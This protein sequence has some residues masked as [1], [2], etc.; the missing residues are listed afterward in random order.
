MSKRTDKS[1]AGHDEP[2]PNPFALAFGEPGGSRT[3]PPGEDASC[4]A[5]GA[6]SSKN[7]VSSVRGDEGGFSDLST[8]PRVV[9]RRERKG[10]GGKTVTVV[11]GVPVPLAEGLAC[12]LR[13]GLGCGSRVEEGVVVLQ[14]DQVER[15]A[16][17]FTARG[18]KKVIRG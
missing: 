3:D 13:K 10:R 7:G 6:V 8:L 16:A 18:V 4:T 11:E 2:L 17:W 15:S 1:S 5:D 9:L 12:A 14:G